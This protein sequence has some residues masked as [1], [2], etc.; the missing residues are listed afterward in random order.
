MSIETHDKTKEQSLEGMLLGILEQNNG[1]CL[2]NEHERVAL[3]TVLATAL[4][5]PEFPH[6]TTDSSAPSPPVE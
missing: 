2:D 3:A 4:M 5:S 1:L 6:Q